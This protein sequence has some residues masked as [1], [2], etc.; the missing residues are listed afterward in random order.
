MFGNNKLIKKVVVSTLFFFTWISVAVDFNFAQN[1]DTL[2]TARSL[3]LDG[4]EK[5]SIKKLN[6]FIDRI[7]DTPGQELDA[8]EAFYLLAKIYYTYQ[9]KG[10]EK[11]VDKNLK[12]VFKKCPDFSREESDPDFKKKVEQIKAEPPIPPIIRGKE[13]TD[14]Q[15]K[16]IKIVFIVDVSPS[17]RSRKNLITDFVGDM[18]NS[19]ENENIKEKEY[20]LI[21]FCEKAKF[22]KPNSQ[23]CKDDILKEIRSEIDKKSENNSLKTYPMY[24]FINTFKLIEKKFPKKVGIVIFIS[25]GEDSRNKEVG[26][27]ELRTAQNDLKQVICAIKK[28]G[29]TVYNVFVD[30]GNDLMCEYCME[31]IAQWSG[32]R[33][34]KIEHQWNIP[35]NISLL[36][37]SVEN[38]NFISPVP[39]MEFNGIEKQFSDLKGRVKEN[40]KSKSNYKII[41][42]ILGVILVGALITITLLIPLTLKLKKTIW[43]LTRPPL[44]ILWGKLDPQ[45]EG[46]KI[47]DLSKKSPRFELTPPQ[48]ELPTLELCPANRKGKKVI[49][50]DHEEGRLKFSSKDKK[51][52]RNHYLEAETCFFKIFHP[53]QKIAHEYRYNFLNKLSEICENPVWKKDEF[54]G[55]DAIVVEIRNNFLQPSGACYHYL[56][57]GMGNSG[58]TSLMKHLYHIG[59]G[60]EDEILQ[61]YSLALVEFNSKDYTTFTGLEKEITKQLE[62]Y[63]GGQRKLILIDEYDKLYEK[64]ED[65]FCEY[66]KKY[67]LNPEYFFILSG[68]KGRDLLGEKFFQHMQSFTHYRKLEGLDYVKSIPGETYERSLEL[69]ESLISDIGFPGSALERNARREIVTYA[70]GFPWLIKKILLE[71]LID[72]LAHFDKKTIKAVHVEGAVDKIKQHAKDFLLRRAI[73]F[74]E[75]HYENLDE[76][77]SKEV[78][79]RDI[80]NKLSVDYKGKGSKREI[81]AALIIHPAGNPAIVAE[82]GKSFDKKIKQLTDMGFIKEDNINE[83]DDVNLIGIPHMCFYKGEEII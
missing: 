42:V 72:W 81:K 9:R 62:S 79:S 60:K 39:R 38:T 19:F 6:K 53:D 70:S 29:F 32:T 82:R 65:E 22:F 52:A 78:L 74:D 16:G 26:K 63:K 77:P 66:I 13:K 49:I 54:K 11:D 2:K 73:A 17:L 28:T 45:K 14:A 58:K 76:I 67:S 75:R 47:I 64:F 7:K 15:E 44:D 56:I 57:S 43:K 18:I 37:N 24:A 35:D 31:M 33:L 51:T 10:W 8:A 80:L 50:I 55:R 69:I 34:I 68:R 1:E 30:T 61:R 20:H 46:L 40:Q 21:T 41:L 83:E 48:E 71:L 4:N 36:R 3:F 5:G 23:I 25:G 27:I 59:L 12:M